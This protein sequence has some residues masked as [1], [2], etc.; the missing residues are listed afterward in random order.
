[1][2]FDLSYI[3]LLIVFTG[4]KI[5]SSKK[6]TSF[7]TSDN[8]AHIF[9]SLGLAILKRSIDNSE[10]IIDLLAEKKCPP[11]KILRRIKK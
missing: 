4:P 10:L 7:E 3:F 2:S 8:A 6:F 11:I 5:S 1:M 9:W